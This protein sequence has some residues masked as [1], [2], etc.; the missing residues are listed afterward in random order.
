M[1]EEMNTYELGTPIVDDEAAIHEVKVKPLALGFNLLD[2]D[3]GTGE[4]ERNFWFLE[5][6]TNLSLNGIKALAFEDY[7]AIKTHISDKL[8]VTDEGLASLV[9]DADGLVFPLSKPINVH[10][11]NVNQI[12]IRLPLKASV[13]LPLDTATG[14]MSKIMKMIEAAANIPWPSV[15]SMAAVDVLTLNEALKPFLERSRKPGKWT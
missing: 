2:M 14:A 12:M 3:R 7:A 5:S 6:M 9:E 8:E 15:K 4:Q 1:A 13:L 10:G 11:E